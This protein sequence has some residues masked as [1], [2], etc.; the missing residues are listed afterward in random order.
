MATRVRIRQSGMRRFMNTDVRRVTR[1]WQFNTATQI[2]V[3]AKGRIR[4]AVEGTR[5]RVVGYTASTTVQSLTGF[6]LYPDQGT[7]VYA[8]RGRIYPRRAKALVFYSRGRL[9]FAKS[10]KG[11]PA[12]HF[13]EE[14]LS[15][16][17]RITFGG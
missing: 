3:R 15:A 6:S 8:G 7:G 12:Q 4:A 11:Q 14:G 17:T 1:R 2:R 16:G 10:I 13:M 9:I 5:I